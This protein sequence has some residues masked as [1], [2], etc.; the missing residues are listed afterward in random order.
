[1]AIAARTSTYTASGAGASL[2]GSEPSG[3]TQDD[4]LFFLVQFDNNTANFSSAPTGWT[5]LNTWTGATFQEGRLYWRRRGASALGAGELTFSISSGAWIEIEVLAFSGCITTGDPWDDAQYSAQSTASAPDAPSATSSGA[6]R[7]AVAFGISWAGGGTGGASAPTNY[8]LTRSGNS[9][10]GV[11]SA[12]RAIGSGAENP[13]A[14]GNIASSDSV[15]AATIILT[16]AS[17][18]T[19]VPVFAYHYKTQGIQ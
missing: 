4:I 2:Q 19:A 15:S 12:Y 10:D 1:M 3:A 6:D 18:A 11:F 14:F 7:V 5:L 8:T 13:G 16:P 17:S 9:G